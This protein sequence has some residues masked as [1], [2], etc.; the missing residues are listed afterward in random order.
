M[1][2]EKIDYLVAT[3]QALTLQRQNALRIG[4]LSEA[5]QIASVAQDVD[6]RIHQ[7]QQSLKL[8]RS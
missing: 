2:K 6:A 8:I 7:L 1:I 5:Q 4:K 3:L